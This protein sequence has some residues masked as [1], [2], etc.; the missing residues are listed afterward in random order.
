MQRLNRIPDQADF[1]RYRVT[2]PDES[3]IL[4]QRLYDFNLYQQAGQTQLSFFSNPIGQGLSTAPGAAAGSAK[5]LHDT[6]MK[7]ANMLPSGNRFIVET[8]EIVFQ[9]GSVSTANTFTPQTLMGTLGAIAAAQVGAVNDAYTFANSGLLSF[10]VLD[11]NYLNEPLMRSFPPQTAFR[12]DTSIAGI[13]TDLT[14]L[15]T[16]GVSLLQCE[17]RPYYLE[18]EIT[19][20]PAVNFGISLNWPGVVALPSGFNARVGVILDGYF[21]RA[22]Q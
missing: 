2:N 11:K 1:A 19:L 8:I 4:R 7:T 21:Q 14:T 17:G 6:N 13:D 20:D 12:L 16:F 15:A 18:P 10:N 3:E 22:A 9:P 5:S